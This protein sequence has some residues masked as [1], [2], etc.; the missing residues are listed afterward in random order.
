MCPLLD[1]RLEL[2]SNMFVDYFAFQS[3]PYTIEYPMHM[4]NQFSCGS[5]LQVSKT[6]KKLQGLKVRSFGIILHKIGHVCPFSGLM[7]WK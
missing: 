1:P 6:A 4:K 2:T 7:F 3:T 5:C